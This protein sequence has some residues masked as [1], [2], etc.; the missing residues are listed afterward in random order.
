MTGVMPR[1]VPYGEPR[2][3]NVIHDVYRIVACFV[4][5]QVTDTG[6]TEGVEEQDFDTLLMDITPDASGEFL[7]SL[8]ERTGFTVSEIVR[9]SVRLMKRQMQSQDA[10]KVILSLVA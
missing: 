3:A 7:Q 5:V 4:L 1:G 9:R 2:S 10:E 8:A 6:P